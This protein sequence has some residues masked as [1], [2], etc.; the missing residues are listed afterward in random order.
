MT[1]QT[2][3]M[4]NPE[5]FISLCRQV[6]LLQ[7]SE[8]TNTIT[9]EDQQHLLLSVCLNYNLKSLLADITKSSLTPGYHTSSVC[10]YLW[11]KKVLEELVEEKSV[12]SECVFMSVT[13]VL[14]VIFS[15]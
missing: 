11:I 5:H 8:T 14:D 1:Y 9:R 7:S 13:K 4:T 15:S 2:D 10:I 12:I 6:D 3:I